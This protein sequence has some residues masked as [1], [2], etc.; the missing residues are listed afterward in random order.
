MKRNLALRPACLLALGC[1][2]G[3]A[4]SGSQVF[5]LSMHLPLQRAGNNPDK[6][7]LWTADST[8]HHEFTYDPL[9]ADWWMFESAAGR[10]LE[11]DYLL[12]MNSENLTNLLDAK[13][14]GD[15]DVK[16]RA[17]GSH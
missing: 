16:G 5:K 15:G 1:L 17:F 14:G 2:I 12:P 8:V 3:A 6:F 4:L 7:Y 11:P 13:L 10:L 9:A